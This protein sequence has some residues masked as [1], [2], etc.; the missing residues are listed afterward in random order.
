MLSSRHGSNQSIKKGADLEK[1][2]NIVYRHMHA[3]KY[4]FKHFYK[5]VFNVNT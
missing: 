4:L 3:N 2:A 1:G 5:N